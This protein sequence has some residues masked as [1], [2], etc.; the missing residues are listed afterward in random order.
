MSGLGGGAMS[1]AG[2]SDTGPGNG[3][4]PR[5]EL[6]GLVLPP[7]AITHHHLSQGGLT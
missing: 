7:Q 3:K 5:Y 4:A 1:I 6:V 2:P